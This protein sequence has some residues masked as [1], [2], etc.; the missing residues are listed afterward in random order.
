MVAPNAPGPGDTFKQGESCSTSWAGDDS[1]STTAWKDMNI[2]LMSGSN[3][4]MVHL[5]TVATGQDG[6]VAGTFDYTCPE[7]TP[8]SAIY[9]YQFTAPGNNGFAWTTRF[10]IAAAD[11]TTTTPTETETLKDGT[12]VPWGHGA[13]VDPST[14]VAAPTFNT[15]GSG[16]SESSGSS[17]SSAGSAPTSGSSTPASSSSP[18]S[19]KPTSSPASRP[20]STSSKSGNATNTAGAAQGS[21]SSAAIAVGPMVVDTRM[22]PVV[23]AMTMSAMAFTLLL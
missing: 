2:E 20:V 7:V 19:T 14:A 12:I 13:L 8:N 22:W 4:A 17:G 1:G 18:S 6:T 23:A 16:S 21:G 10:T 9:F 5:T 15:T 11:G 3:E